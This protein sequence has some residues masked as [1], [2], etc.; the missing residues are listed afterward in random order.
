MYLM[1]SY[2]TY[3]ILRHLAFVPNLSDRTSNQNTKSKNAI[4]ENYN[5]DP[6]S[7][8]TKP[9]QNPPQTHPKPSKMESKSTLGPSKTPFGE[10]SPTFVKL[11]C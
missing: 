6:P 5:F 7:S 9:S 2:D 1:L 8:P 10:M 4:Q 3:D 11:C